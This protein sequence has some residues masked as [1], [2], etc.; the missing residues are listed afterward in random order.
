MRS[1]KPFPNL[2][3]WQS[4]I[5]KALGHHAG[6]AFLARVQS[7]YDKLFEQARHYKNKALRQHFENNILPAVAAYSILLEDKKDQESALQIM[8]RL[9][10]ASI[11][12]ERA[13]YRFWGR[14]PF[15]FDLLC[16]MLKPKMIVQYPERWNIEWLDLGHNV[17][18]LNCHAC[19]YLDILTEYGFTE[20]TAHFCRLDDLL[21]AEAAPSIRFER[22]QTLGRGGKMCDFR[23]FR[24]KR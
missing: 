15:F 1:Y 7:K 21:A 4:E 16:L 10:E 19:F 23:Y 9:L 17:V 2:K 14:F 20:L 13:T 18:G 12:S 3:N 22:T 11:E 5:E 8:D 6:I 24:V